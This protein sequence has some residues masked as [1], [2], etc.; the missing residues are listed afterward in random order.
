MRHLTDI[1]VCDSDTVVKLPL[2]PDLRSGPFFGMVCCDCNLY[3]RFYF[4]LKDGQVYMRGDRDDK[5]TELL[6]SEDAKFTKDGDVVLNSDG[7]VL[8]QVLGDVGSDAATHHELFT[9]SSAPARKAPTMRTEGRRRQRQLDALNADCF[10]A[11]GVMRDGAVYRV[12]M[13]MRDSTVRAGGRND[14]LVT[15]TAKIDEAID[16]TKRAMQSDGSQISDAELRMHRPG[17]RLAADSDDDDDRR[18]RRR[19]TVE[20][21]PMG[22]EKA[23]FEEDAHAGLSPG[24]AARALWM[25]EMSNAW[26]T[27]PVTLDAGVGYSNS[28]PPGTGMPTRSLE[29][30][31]PRGG[32]YPASA[33]VGSSC[34]IDG[35]SGSLQPAGNGQLYCR[36]LPAIGATRS[37]R[38]AG[39][40][41]RPVT[42]G[43]GVDPP[44]SMTAEDAAAING[45]AYAAMVA[46]LNTAWRG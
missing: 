28:D 27:P 16:I 32:Y 45:E 22:R 36:P 8:F 43:N 31:P 13:H 21:D 1:P 44:R 30:V 23:T 6:R 42:G 40:A 24:T 38:S 41:Q 12:P 37:G 46:E 19:K 15:D 7:S 9:D 26:R 17:Y 4:K 14:R 2:S 34:M 39:D 33:G 18:R 11:D 10:D 20:R 5:Q 35:Q 25:D 3:H 29:M